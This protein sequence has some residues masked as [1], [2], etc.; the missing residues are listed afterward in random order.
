MNEC[1]RN[2]RAGQRD[3]FLYLHEFRKPLIFFIFV[4]LGIGTYYFYTARSLGEP[5]SS[6]AEAYY[7]IL[8]LAFFQ[9]SGAFPQPGALQIWF[10]YTPHHRHRHA[11]AGIG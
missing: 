1:A 10:L 6:L 8:G 2:L 7:M 3:T 4:I 5:L 9:P 11:R